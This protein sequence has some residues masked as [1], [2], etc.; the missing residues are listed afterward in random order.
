MKN[1][2]FHFN[3]IYFLFIVSAI[4]YSFRDYLNK[5]TIINEI[6]PSYKL[7][8]MYLGETLSGFIYLGVK[9]SL[10]ENEKKLSSKLFNPFEERYKKKRK[11]SLKIYFTIFIGALID[12]IGCY[13]YKYFYNYNMIKFEKIF[14]E[15]E[16]LCLCIF[17]CL[18]ESYY[19]NLPKYRHHY[20]GLILIFISLFIVMI[21][22]LINIGIEHLYY[23]ILF[24]I[25]VIESQCIMSFFHSLEKILNYRYFINIY[26]LL[27]LEGLFGFLI[28]I[29]SSGIYTIFD[30]NYIFNIFEKI[31]TE[32]LIYS[33]FYILFSLFFNIIKLKIIEIKSPSYNIIPNLLRVIIIDIFINKRD[34]TFDFLLYNIF[35]LLGAF[36]FC[37]IITLNFFNLDENTIIKTRERGKLETIDTLS[38]LNQ[39]NI[40]IILN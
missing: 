27:F 33:F 38:D 37:E 2:T 3:H 32:L 35:S 15:L 14:D 39:L 7:I 4:L 22:N 6:L 18:N 13:N 21:T 19:L 29:L 40:S 23:F 20:L 8:I 28:M 16:I 9:Y 25:N 36:I 10:N 31:N 26:K 1:I 17:L 11:E 34:F 30:H 12:G 24:L 5:K